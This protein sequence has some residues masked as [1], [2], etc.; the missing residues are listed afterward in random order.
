MIKLIASDMD[1]TL[2][3]HDKQ[4][5]PH[6]VEDIVQMKKHGAR[7]VV[8]SGRM[9]AT[10]QM[11]FPQ[12]VAECDCI[13]D[14]GAS[15]I[16]AGEFTSLSIIHPD[17]V[18][19]LAAYAQSLS[20]DMRVVLCGKKD[21]YIHE[22]RENVELTRRLMNGFAMFTVRENFAGITDD[23]FKLSICLG[24]QAIPLVYPALVQKYGDVLEI[25]RSGPYYLD[26]MNKGV[27]KGVALARMQKTHGV[28]KSET[29]VFGD[30][31]ND[32]SMLAQA[33]YSFT[34]ENSEPEM[35]KHAN[36]LAPSNAEYGVQTV[37]KRYVIE[38]EPLPILVK[39]A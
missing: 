12:L 34:L 5:P 15:V 21:S 25:V 6:F 39:N 33:D 36:F 13:C 27:S 37:I 28:L 24:E 11:Q 38:E 30:Y 3:T 7:F 4:L 31:Y 29:M 17:R 10:L 9:Y 22:Y 2:L 14:N 16:E 23:V 20:E 32:V 19:E 26:V 35:R 1:G 18:Q 8:A